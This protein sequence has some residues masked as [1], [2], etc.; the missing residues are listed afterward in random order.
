MKTIQ[1]KFKTLFLLLMLGFAF[2]S[3][4]SDDDAPQDDNNEDVKKG[5]ATAVVGLDD[6]TIQ[7]SAK[8]DNSFAAIIETK[9]GE[10]DIKQLIIVMADDKPDVTIVAQ[11]TPAP[12]NPINYDLSSPITD[13]YFFTTGVA[14]DG[15][16]SS[17]ANVYGVGFYQHGDDI[18]RQSKGAFKITS[19]SST[20]IKGTFD[21]TLY[22]SYNS[23]DTFDAKE[24]TVTEGKFD[25]PMVKLSQKDLEDLGLE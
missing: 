8:S 25:L 12:G 24:L 2:V 5:Q 16:N 21:M 10:N 13:D 3:C 11:V 4:S 1:I 15:K 18:V 6:K 20:N 22:N 17:D 7:F 23:N 9:L 19:I 14:V